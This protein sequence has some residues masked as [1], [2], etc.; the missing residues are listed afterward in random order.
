MLAGGIISMAF[1][2]RVRAWRET[3]GIK[4]AELARRSGLDTATI[5]RIEHGKQ[6][7]PTTDTVQRLATALGITPVELMQEAAPAGLEGPPLELARAVGLSPGQLRV[8][9]TTWAGWTLAA[10]RALL[11][12]LEGLRADQA[13]V[14][15]KRRQLL[16]LDSLPD[17]S[18]PDLP[19]QDN[20]LQTSVGS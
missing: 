19:K 20:K 6:T 15:A 3:L 14:E 8:L 4:Q 1:G 11:Q 5:S 9:E 12:E 7:N 17:S 13:A 16:H 18:G 10:R 2:D